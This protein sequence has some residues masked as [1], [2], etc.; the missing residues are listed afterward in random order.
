M[1]AKRKTAKGRATAHPPTLADEAEDMADMLGRGHY[2]MSDAITMI[3]RC[4]TELRSK[5]KLR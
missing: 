3:R 1:A 4:A 2:S 5:S